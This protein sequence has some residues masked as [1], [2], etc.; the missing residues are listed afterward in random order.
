MVVEIIYPKSENFFNDF[1]IP[2]RINTWT[3]KIQY[4]APTILNKTIDLL[5]RDAYCMLS[6]LM[7]DIYPKEEWNYVFGLANKKKRTGVFS[8]ARYDPFF[9]KSENDELGFN[10]YTFNQ[11]ET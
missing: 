5:P 10:F 7:K 9:F 4:H 11:E 8:F 2:N 3:N 6:I 1:Q